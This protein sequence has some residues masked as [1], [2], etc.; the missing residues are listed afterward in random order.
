MLASRTHRLAAFAV[1]AAAL[2]AVAAAAPDANLDG[3]YTVK[4]GNHYPNK[5]SLI[6]FNGQTEWSVNVSLAASC[7]SYT[8]TCS[9]GCQYDWNKLWGKTR[10]ADSSNVQTQQ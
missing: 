3:C 8:C 5:N 2:L 6:A 9:D 1:A 10:C 4:E 7:A